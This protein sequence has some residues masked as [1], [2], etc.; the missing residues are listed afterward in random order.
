MVKNHE[1]LSIM[2]LSKA[3]EREEWGVIEHSCAKCK[4]QRASGSFD[5]NQCAAIEYVL[6]FLLLGW[7]YMGKHC[8]FWQLLR[9][10][11]GYTG[12]IG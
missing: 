9:W 10:G 7:G 2:Q 3:K 12:V 1:I 5:T 11:G 4:Q 8:P 6:S